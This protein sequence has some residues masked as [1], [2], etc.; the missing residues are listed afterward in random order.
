MNSS[1]FYLYKQKNELYLGY[2]ISKN[3]V[4]SCYQVVEYLRDLVWY[5]LYLGSSLTSEIQYVNYKE[6]Q[7][8]FSTLGK[9]FLEKVV[10]LEKE[11]KLEPIASNILQ[12]DGFETCE[13]NVPCLEILFGQNDK[14]KSLYESFF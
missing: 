14:K 12:D 7:P 11:Y 8:L 2:D 3:E 5:H 6:L 10:S 1:D 13:E 4:P 9:N